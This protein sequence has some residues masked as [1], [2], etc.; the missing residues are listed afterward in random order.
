MDFLFSFTKKRMKIDKIVKIR[1]KIN[2]VDIAIL[3]HN[4]PA[5]KDAGRA[6]SPITIW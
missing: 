6:E 4:I 2:G 3:S 5:I 1:E